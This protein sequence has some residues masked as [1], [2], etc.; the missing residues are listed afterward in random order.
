MGL[1]KSLLGAPPRLQPREAAY[2]AVLAESEERLLSEVN[3]PEGSELLTTAQFGLRMPNGIVVWNEWC[4]GGLQIPFNNP[5]DR[6]RMVANL[7][8]TALDLGFDIEQFLEHYEWVTRN[9]IAI[10]RYEDTGSYHLTHPSVTGI[11][12]VSVVEEQARDDYY[13]SEDESSKETS[14]PDH[15][16]GEV[17]SGPVGSTEGGGS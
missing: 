13:D 15:N 12:A 14:A 2:E 8:K 10:V 11:A 7:Q 16:G 4:E 1:I 3:L 5:L 6:L 9:Q 17:C